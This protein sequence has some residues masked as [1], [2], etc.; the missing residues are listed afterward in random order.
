[1]VIF[2]V[3]GRQY[4]GV[5]DQSGNLLTVPRILLCILKQLLYFVASHILKYISN[6]SSSRNSFCLFDI[7]ELSIT[8]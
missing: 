8:I 5:L 3:L 4:F 2:R 1:M 6:I 7:N